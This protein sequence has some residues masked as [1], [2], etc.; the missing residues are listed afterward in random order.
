MEWTWMMKRTLLGALA[1]VT[2]LS[3]LTACGGS[4]DENETAGQ[5][6]SPTSQVQAPASPTEAV[7]TQAPAPATQAQAT[8]APAPTTAAAAPAAPAVQVLEVKA[9]DYYYE[10]SGLTAKV[11]PVK[12]TMA[13]SGPDRP[14]TVN[15][16]NRNGSG[17]L[18]KSERVNVGQSGSI[19]FTVMEAGTYE[20]YCSLPGHADRGQKGMLTV[21]GL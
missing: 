8:Q 5:T 11:G 16:R 3:L 2:L 9:G 12:I 4:D 13:N 19:E 15:V 10:P 17:D 20:V 21:T 1:G 6:E 7:A 18:V 14:H